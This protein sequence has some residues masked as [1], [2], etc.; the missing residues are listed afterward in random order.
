MKDVDA[1]SSERAFAAPDHCTPCAQPHEGADRAAYEK[2]LGELFQELHQTERSAK[3]HCEREAR[4]YEGT[5]PAHAMRAVSR[6]ADAILPELGELSRI[7]DHARVPW[8]QALGE[9]FSNV[10]QLALDR[11]LD[12]QRSYRG[13]LLGLHHGV[14]LVRLLLSCAQTA[15]DSVLEAFC[16]R[17][18]AERMPLL[19]QAVLAMRWFADHPERARKRATAT[20]S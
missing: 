13:T 16:T 5:P 10:R 7:E 4:R 19:E 18:L 1:A 17:W 14:D 3:R 20:R 11:M 12:G 6:H 8:G 2:L 15:R 9:L